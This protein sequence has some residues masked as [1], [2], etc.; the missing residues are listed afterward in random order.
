MPDPLLSS[1]RQKT[2][3]EEHRSYYAINTTYVYGQEKYLLVSIKH[4]ALII[5]EN[6]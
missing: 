1:Q 2:I 4:T 6:T 3:K 5:N